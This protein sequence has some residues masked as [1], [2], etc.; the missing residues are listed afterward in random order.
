MKRTPAALVGGLVAAAFALSA[1]PALA[2]VTATAPAAA[3]PLSSCEAPDF[4]QPFTAL[5]DRHYYTLAPDGDFAA[6]SDTDWEL[7]GGAQVVQTTQPGGSTGGVLELPSRSEAVSPVMC[8]SVDY[9]TARLAV[10]NVVGGDG[11]FF[12]VS[13]LK[14][15]QWSAPKNTGQFHGEHSDWTVSKPMNL[16]PTKTSGWQQVRFVFVAGGNASRF[17]VDDFWVDPRLRY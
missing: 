1:S 13:Y 3:A 16:Q 7:I 11:V 17:Q 15:G 14:N 12:Y 5:K 8:V 4:S 2:G 6:G 9:P 10:R